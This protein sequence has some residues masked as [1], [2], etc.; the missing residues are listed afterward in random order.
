MASPPLNSR[1]ILPCSPTL[2]LSG[3]KSQNSEAQSV[4]KPSLETTTEDLK[5]VSRAV[6]ST[7][8]EQLFE[9]DLPEGKGTK[10]N[11]LTTAEE[12]VVVQILASLRGDIQPTLLDQELRSPEHVPHSTQ[13]VFDQTPKS[14]DVDTKEEEEEETPMVWRIKGVQGENA[15]NLKV[16]DP[17]AIVV[18][19]EA[20]LDDE[21]TESKR[22]RKRKGKGKMV[23]SQNK[24]GIKRRYVT[25]GETQ[26]LMGDAL[27]ENK[28]QT[29]RNWR[30]KMKGHVPDEELTSTP[31]HVGSCKM[32]F[33]DIV[34]AMARRKEEVEV[35]RVKAKGGPKLVKRS[36]VKNDKVNKRAPMKPKP[37]KGPGP[38]VQKPVE[39]N[40]LTR[41]ERIAE[42]EKQ[43]VLNGRVFDPEILT[44]F[45][46][47]TLFD[48]VTLQSW[49]H[50]FEVSA[51]YLHEPEV[52]E[53]YY[54]MELLSDGGI[55]IKVRGVK[56]SLNEEILGIILSVPVE[57]IRSIE[58][59]KPFGEFS[60]QA[61]QC[62]DIKRAGLPK[63]F[64]RGEYQLMFE[65]I[66]KIL[67]PRTKKRT[68]ASADLF[69]IEKLD[70]LEAINLSAIMLEHMHMVMTWKTAKHG[71][72]YGY[73]L[74]YVFKHFEVPLGRGVPDTVKQMFSVATLLECEC[75]EGKAKGRSHVSDL[76]EQQ[77]SLR[78]E[79]IDLTITLY[80]KEGEIAQLKAQMQQTISKGPGTS[81]VDKEEVERLRAENV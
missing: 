52:R 12:L 62:G 11:I 29:E 1:E 37:V 65:F 61:T 10:S 55:T 5:V 50:L 47:S 44:E 41:E 38:S 45:S 20:K 71:I 60:Q 34:K 49:E 57:G 18:V 63:K 36:P 56:I 19:F 9:G 25:R 67:L 64:L 7:M 3:E 69:L 27:A 35:E 75:V 58:G 15:V 74:N 16:S 24:G 76:L 23:D 46:M 28:E 40:V 43:K 59:C 70:E 68:V 81:S 72:P 66:N 51:P 14:F 31:L 21:P 8:S 77:V 17:E 79:L 4:V 13:T 80:A 42:M 53:F 2:V 26:K 32:E 54:K 78:Q 33:D 48:S 6:S 22:K 73:I 30:Q 39:E